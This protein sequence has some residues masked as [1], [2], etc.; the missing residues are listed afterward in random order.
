MDEEWFSAVHVHIEACGGDAVDAAVDAANAASRIQSSSSS[1]S[2]SSSKLVPTGSDPAPPVHP[3]KADTGDGATDEEDVLASALERMAASV[4]SCTS[5][6]RRMEERYRTTHY[7]NWN[8]KK[9]GR[10]C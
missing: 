10:H 3:S 4:R 1:S 5:A 9:S 8:S 7:T 2:N 6:L